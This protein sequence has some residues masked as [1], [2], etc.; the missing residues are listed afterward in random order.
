[1]DVFVAFLPWS[2]ARLEPLEDPPL[3]GDHNVEAQGRSSRYWVVA[4]DARG[5]ELSRVERT[6]LAHAPRD[7]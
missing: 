6:N 4:Y 5:H 1:V 3:W 7:S 2:A